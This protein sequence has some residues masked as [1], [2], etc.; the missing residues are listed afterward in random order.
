MK[1]DGT[2]QQALHL[3]LVGVRPGAA[4]GLEIGL[5]VRLGRGCQRPVA[6]PGRSAGRPPRSR[7]LGSRGLP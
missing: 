3:L 2:D 7:R 1:G 4:V 6:L 5:R